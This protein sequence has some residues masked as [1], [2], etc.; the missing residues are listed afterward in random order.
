MPRNNRNQQVRHNSTSQAQSKTN[1]PR[2][3]QKAAGTRF[4]TLLDWRAASK[5]AENT[6]PRHGQAIRDGRQ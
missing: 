4:G 2:F 5:G 1:A 3:G 6:S